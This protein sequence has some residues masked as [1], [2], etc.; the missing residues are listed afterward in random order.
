MFNTLRT[1][2]FVAPT[3]F[4]PAL[5]FNSRN[6]S[7]SAS[8]SSNTRIDAFSGTRNKATICARTA[9]DSAQGRM[10]LRESFDGRS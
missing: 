6:S 10:Y 5:G 4:S 7:A 2:Y 9:K 8:I 3:D 1:G